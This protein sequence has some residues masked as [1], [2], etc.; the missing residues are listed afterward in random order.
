MTKGGKNPRQHDSDEFGRLLGNVRVA[1]NRVASRSRIGDYEEDLIQSVILTLWTGER[2]PRQ[3]PSHDE[4]ER[5]VRK[6]A[7]K[8]VSRRRTENSWRARQAK[9]L[10]ERAARN[11]RA[12]HQSPINPPPAKAPKEKGIP[13]LCPRF[14]RLAT[15]TAHEQRM[16]GHV[17]AA[18]TILACTPNFLR[19]RQFRAFTMAYV[20]GLSC[21]DVAV[22]LHTTERGATE[23]LSRVVARID[24]GLIKLLLPCADDF[25]T[26]IRNAQRPESKEEKLGKSV[27]AFRAAT[28]EYVID[29]LGALIHKEPSESDT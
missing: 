26:E 6:L 25:A 10:R 2:A 13:R 22:A 9:A 15:G 5:T 29:V 18:A 12:T 14:E 3:P 1:A 17:L 27:S 28:C 16:A 21:S 23:T 7:A 8:E 19:T 4:I 24:L 20:Q 11:P